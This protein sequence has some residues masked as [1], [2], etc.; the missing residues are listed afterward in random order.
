MFRCR[1]SQLRDTDLGMNLKTIILL[2]A[3]SLSGANVPEQ[4]NTVRHS[5][6]RNE[7]QIANFENN[8]DGSGYKACGIEQETPSW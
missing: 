1:H 8:I 7:R 3:V 2:A 6:R 5:F 4:T